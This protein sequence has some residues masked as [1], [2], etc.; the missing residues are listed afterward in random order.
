MLWYGMVWCR[1]DTQVV[2]NIEHH[3]LKKVGSNDLRTADCFD[4]DPIFPTNG[5]FRFSVPMRVDDWRNY[6]F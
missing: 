4:D 6:A 3:S 5:M 1:Y 2:H